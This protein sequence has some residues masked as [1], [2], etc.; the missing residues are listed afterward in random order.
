MISINDPCLDPIQSGEGS[1]FSL[2]LLP[3]PCILST[4]TMADAQPSPTLYI[5]NLD[6][7]ISKD[8]PSCLSILLVSIYIQL[9]YWIGI[10]PD[11]R[12]LLYVYFSSYGKVLDVVAV[13]NDK[14]RGQAFI[15]FKDLSTSTS[16]L[17]KEDGRVFAGKAMRIQYARGKSYASIENESGKEALYQYRIGIVKN[18]NASRLTVSGAENALVSA[19]K[20]K[21]RENGQGNGAEDG[22]DM[23][24]EDDEEEEEEGGDDAASAAKKQKTNGT[25]A[26]AEEEGD[27]EM[28]MDDSDDDDDAPG[29]PAA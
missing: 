4:S 15:V 3:H 9:I 22:S 26:P 24:E 18:P 23:E 2:W 17:R 7:K 6:S 21:E 25:A 19:A 1:P 28:Q 29:P 12:H 14:M 10:Q 20:R 16:A 8:G 5:Q 27:D 11:L 13:K